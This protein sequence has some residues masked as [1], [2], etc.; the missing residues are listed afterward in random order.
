VI[1]C[2]A[3]VQAACVPSGPPRAAPIEWLPPVRLSNL[4]GAPIDVRALVQGKAALINFWAT[5]CDSCVAEVDSLKRLDAQASARNDALVIGVAVGE[6]RE[7][8]EAFARRRSL[9]YAQL[10]DED[11]RLADALGQREVPATV[12]V[13]RTGRIIYR[14]GALDAAGLAAFRR[15]LEPPA[16]TRG[17]D[18]ERSAPP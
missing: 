14:G 8:V 1:F 6:A 15:A 2:V 16:A 13:D 5:W 18:A 11:F 12:V 3:S 17:L 9:A 4:D 10:I 7:T